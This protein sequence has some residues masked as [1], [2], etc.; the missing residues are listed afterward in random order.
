MKLTDPEIW[1]KVQRR[2]GPEVDW[3][4]LFLSSISEKHRSNTLAFDVASDPTLFKALVPPE[5][6]VDSSLRWLDPRP[7]FHPL[8]AP[9]PYIKSQIQKR[10]SLPGARQ[11]RSV[12]GQAHT[13]FF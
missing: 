3:S 8:V 5:K 1:P 6:R 13:L 4:S 12:L 10:P 9:I 7:Y 2:L 11:V